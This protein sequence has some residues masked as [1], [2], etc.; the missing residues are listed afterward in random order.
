MQKKIIVSCRIIF[1][2][3]KNS[4]QR[5][6]PK[7]APPRLDGKRVGVF[8][9]RS[10]HRPNAVGLTLAKIM[11]LEGDTLHLC[12]LDLLDMTPIIDIK[13]YIPSYDAPQLSDYEH[14]EFLN[15]QSVPDEK[16]PQICSALQLCS[17]DVQ[18]VSVDET[19]PV[20]V[21]SPAWTSLGKQTIKVTFTTSSLEQIDLFSPTSHCSDY[22]LTHL[23]SSDEAIRAITDI[24]KEDP[25]S[26]YRRNK[27][28][29]RLY[30]CIVDAMHVTTWFDEVNGKCEVLRVM[31]YS[32]RSQ[33]AGHS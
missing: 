1:I 5:T 29:D 8:S 15:D 27:C 24:L 21:A 11:S 19:T 16:S 4:T 13:P 20:T 22:R 30:F 31:P 32:L 25:R 14:A 26:V 2:F 12:G 6:K 23:K 7:V 28:Q 18:Q 9:T 33:A 17:E 3:H 10:P